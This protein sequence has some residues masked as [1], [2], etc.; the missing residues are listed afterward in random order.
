MEA[1]E[2]PAAME[3]QHAAPATPAAAIP[4]DV[5][6]MLALLSLERHGHALCNTL[7][8]MSAAAAVF[9]TDADLIDIGMKP[10]ERRAFLAAAAAAAGGGRADAA[11]P[12]VAVVPDAASAASSD[13][14][15]ATDVVVGDVEGLQAERPSAGASGCAL[16][17][18]ASAGA[19]SAPTLPAAQSFR[20]MLRPP[21]PDAARRRNA[22]YEEGEAAMIACLESLSKALTPPEH[23]VAARLRGCLGCVMPPSLSG[24]V[25]NDPD[26]FMAFC[27]GLRRLPPPTQLL[28]VMAGM[29]LH[30]RHPEV[31]EAALLACSPYAA[32]GSAS[33]DSGAVQTTVTVYTAADVALLD[34]LMAATL[35]AV[36]CFF[37]DDAQLCAKALQVVSAFGRRPL[38]AAPFPPQQPRARL[39]AVVA[40]IMQDHVFFVGVQS[41]GVAALCTLLALRPDQVVIS[42]DGFK[43]ALAW[44]TAGVLLLAMQAARTALQSVVRSRA[45]EP[46]L[47]STLAH[48][49][50]L[51]TF[52][53]QWATSARPLPPALPVPVEFRLTV[54]R[55]SDPPRFEFNPAFKQTC[56]DVLA[57]VLD[58]FEEHVRHTI[59]SFEH[60]ERTALV[61]LRRFLESPFG[62]D[63]LH[64]T[65][66]ERA[67]AFALV[68]AEEE[69]THQLMAAL[70]LPV[71]AVSPVAVDA[72]AAP[73]AAPA[74]EQAALIDSLLEEQAALRQRIDNLKG[75]GKAVPS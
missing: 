36:L 59:P 17:E 64:A 51:A 37:S 61:V 49:T 35:H 65:D 55:P 7:G 45:P 74:G 60:K 47:S 18:E 33:A 1:V 63:L 75:K 31:V 58:V 40:E 43:E 71:P 34:P 19:R 11:R 67:F 54:D 28:H 56:G 32:M 69:S 29:L 12:A 44:H 8:L 70:P 53:L 50:L 39:A 10:I 73:A 57:F 23:G 4:P 15:S 14:L 3:E 24:V 42:I 72:S 48:A 22:R 62:L 38:G 52:V 20:P 21:L 2:E 6:T 30:C 9:V 41:A 13:L 66:C 27:M 5:A 26:A 68:G 46:F 25:S 16:T